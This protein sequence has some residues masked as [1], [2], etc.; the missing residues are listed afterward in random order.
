MRLVWCLPTKEVA[1]HVENG[2]S[3]RSTIRKGP[4]V[5]TQPRMAPSVELSEGVIGA[6][7]ERVLEVGPWAIPQTRY[8]P[9]TDLEDDVVED[10]GSSQ[11][12]SDQDLC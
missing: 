5:A 4:R 11:S 10:E 6:G 2:K 9:L 1:L 7:K 12:E 3:R 8:E